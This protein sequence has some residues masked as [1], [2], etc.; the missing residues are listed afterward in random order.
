MNLSFSHLRIDAHIKH[1]GSR[2]GHIIGYRKGEPIYGTIDPKRLHHAHGRLLA[3]KKGVA[4]PG[5]GIDARTK[6]TTKPEKLAAWHHI[7]KEHGHHE[8]AE[9]AHLKLKGLSVTVGEEKPK[10]EDKPKEG[11][12]APVDEK[13]G[14]GYFYNILKNK[15]VPLA[16]G[17]IGGNGDHDGWIALGDNAKEI[18]VDPHKARAFQ[19]AMYGFMVGPEHP[20]WK[21]AE[22]LPDE[23]E[24]RYFNAEYAD[25]KGV[26]AYNKWFVKAFGTESEDAKYIKFHQLMRIRQWPDGGPMSITTTMETK[27]EVMEHLGKLSK[28]LLKVGEPRSKR[29]VVSND[30]VGTI[31]DT[32][33]GE[34]AK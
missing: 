20:L 19:T 9:R 8:H 16:T 26:K 12:R 18:G 31:L 21:Y 3:L 23:S 25:P 7:L 29:V 5:P 27:E 33:L 6:K 13:D 24:G 1:P 34:L 2:G 11:E 22:E 4:D 30:S 14:Y 28:Q 10:E 17:D 15:L 32:T